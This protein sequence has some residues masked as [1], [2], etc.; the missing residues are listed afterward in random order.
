MATKRR[1]VASP[2]EAT[3][4]HKRLKDFLTP[5]EIDRLLEGT[6]KGRHGVRDYL[7]VLMIYRHGL[8]VSEAIGLRLE[9]VNL[10]RARLWVER[11]KGSD[12]TE[13]PIVGDELRALR[14]YLK[15]R[16]D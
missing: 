6:K 1:N 10:N 8:R 9:A 3:D 13:Q 11:L 15:T 7:L 2:R 5:D 14:R 4:S 16:K 12:S